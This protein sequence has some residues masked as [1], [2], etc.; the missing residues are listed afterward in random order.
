MKW[1][2]STL[3]SLGS[4]SIKQLAAFICS[5]QIQFVIAL[6]CLS[7]YMISYHQNCIMI[8]LVFES[9]RHTR[10]LRY[11]SKSWSVNCGCFRV[12]I[13]IHKKYCEPKILLR[14]ISAAKI[15]GC[16]NYRQNSDFVK[17][18][19]AKNCQC[20]QVCTLCLQIPPSLMI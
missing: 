6:Q 9:P 8:Y 18:F 19:R 4:L 14:K 7:K 10:R 12:H 1:D 5:K 13:I 11:N 3:Q 20:S 15:F 16:E 2:C 17:N